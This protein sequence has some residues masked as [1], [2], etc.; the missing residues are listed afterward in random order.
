MM[1][2]MAR[3]VW[4]TYCRLY[5][6][7]GEGPVSVPKVLSRMRISEPMCRKV[8]WTLGRGGLLERVGKEGREVKFRI[9]PPTEAVPKLVLSSPH[10]RYRE[11][12]RFFGSIQGLDWYVVGTTALNYHAP[13]H[14]PTIELASK[15]PVQLRKKAKGF[16][17]ICFQVSDEVPAEFEEAELEGIHFKISS[18]EDAV[19]QAYANY[20]NTPIGV[21]GLDYM[22]AIAMRAK[23]EHLNTK[24]FRELPLG[25]RKHLRRVMAYLNFKRDLTKEPPAD[26]VEEEAWRRRFADTRGKVV[27]MVDTLSLGA[28]MWM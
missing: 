18:V 4:N 12:L 25:A 8:V 26:E 5:G 7:F 22:A 3:K 1:G 13:Y 27:D 9:V 10:V 20:P 15:R 21:S 19:V 28:V 2:M 16:G 11:V 14:A 6:S 24:R 17:H 23:G